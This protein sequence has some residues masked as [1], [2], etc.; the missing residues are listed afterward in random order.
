[1]AA[2]FNC[3]GRCC[4]KQRERV[5]GGWGFRGVW[6]VGGGSY[7]GLRLEEAPLVSRAS[8]RCSSGREGLFEFRIKS[9]SP[10]VANFVLSITYRLCTRRKRR[11]TGGQEGIPA[12]KTLILVYKLLFLIF[13]CITRPDNGFLSWFERFLIFH[14]VITYDSLC[15]AYK[16]SHVVMTFQA[17]LAG[18]SKDLIGGSV[19]FN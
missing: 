12:P 10:K 2:A 11:A 14:G 9:L 8:P 17:K 4:V 3:S 18:L 1:M 6:G 16:G 5:G 7:E 19:T 13:Q 15:S